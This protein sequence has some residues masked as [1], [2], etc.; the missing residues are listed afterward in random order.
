MRIWIHFRRCNVHLLQLAWKQKTSHNWK[1]KINKLTA[2]RSSG[3]GNERGFRAFFLRWWEENFAL[4]HNKRKLYFCISPFIPESLRTWQS[5]PFSSVIRFNW[6]LKTSSLL[7]NNNTISSGEEG[8]FQ[9]VQSRRRLFDVITCRP[10]AWGIQKNR[11][12]SLEAKLTFQQ[13]EF[14]PQININWCT[15]RKIYFWFYLWLNYPLS[16][17]HSVGGMR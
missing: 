3:R 10:Q 5:A 17:K 6:I 13:I 8:K 16:W 4:H 9:L 7:A 2:R 11:F 15:R 1:S 14:D 12:A